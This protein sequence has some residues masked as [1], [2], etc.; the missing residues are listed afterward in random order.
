MKLTLSVS[1]GVGVLLQIQQHAR[2]SPMTAA[3][4]A[5]GCR[6]PR[7][8][9]YRILHKMVN[10]G[11]LSGTSGPGGGYSLARR[12]EQIT[13]LDIAASVD[14]QPQPS[15]LK[16]VCA[17][18]AGAIRRVNDLCRESARH[19]ASELSRVR[20]VDLERIDGRSRRP[21]RGHS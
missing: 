15:Q 13:L 8:F 6:F 19:F 11:L 21:P 1:Y 12:P 4:I 18:Q 14:S 10:A 5:R 2:G 7:R 17:H 9:L 16:P 3:R 20:L